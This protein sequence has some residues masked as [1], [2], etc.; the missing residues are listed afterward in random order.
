MANARNS[1]HSKFFYSSTMEER[2]L[3]Q[4]A[5]HNSQATQNLPFYKWI[6]AV[7][8]LAV[9]GLTTGS[10]NLYPSQRDS[11]IKA[12]NIS[13]GL[14]TFMLTGGVMIMYLSLPAGIFM[15]HFG[16]N[17]TL[18][19]SAILTIAS[20]IAL[21]FCGDYSWL[22]IT[23][24]LLM[25]FGSSSLFIVCLQLV[26]SRAPPK[27]KGVSGLIV[28]ASLSLS[29]GMFLEIYK[30]GK[31]AF[32]CKGEDCVFSSFQLVSI[33]VISMIIVGAPSAYFFYRGFPQVGNK[34]SKKSWDLFKDV[35]LY[36]FLIGM[37][38][39]VFDGMI[40]LEAG[41]HV[42]KLYGKG[43]PNGASDWGIV[44]SVINCIM[45]IALS[46]ILDLL[47]A[48]CNK[49]ASPENK[50]SIE[51]KNEST[52]TTD[53]NSPSANT[54]NANKSTNISSNFTRNKGFGLFWLVIGVIP[55]ANGIL[56][57]STD[58]EKL[59][60]VFLSMMGIPFGFGLTQIPALVSDV[61]GNDKYGFAFGIAQ[62]GSII[63]SAS[64][65]PI[66]LKLNEN[67]IMITFF[68]S[69]TCHLILGVMMIFMKRSISEEEEVINDAPLIQDEN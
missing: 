10:V 38:V 16:G 62:I 60:G 30:A 53:T 54:T 61:F 29:F 3:S 67:G 17:I 31:N 59:F 33:V 65:M 68:I 34:P 25:A 51:I 43:Y 64:A 9:T 52:L 55:L 19:V 7:V 46:A 32:K 37:F 13:D 5:A 48:K 18:L 41:D 8:F 11:I 1:I 36:T 40:V 24:Y 4:T 15:D 56:Y 14:G 22:F 42:W 63:A 47:I 26:F 2:L 21:P 44:F 35:K 45:T 66:L 12:L 57:K 20:Y 6:L 23:L 58:D 39:T 50:Y 27:I 28:S 49:T 69:S